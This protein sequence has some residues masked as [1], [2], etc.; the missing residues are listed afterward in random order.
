MPVI[1]LDIDG[2]RIEWKKIKIVVNIFNLHI[3]FE[4]SKWAKTKKGFHLYLYIDN[5]MK[6]EDICFFQLAMGSDSR[7]E[8]LNWFR[9]KYGKDFLKENWNVLFSKKYAVGLDG[10]VRLTS[11]EKELPISVLRKRLE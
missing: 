7:R 3:D 9:L 10:R 11:D 5:N 4:Q 1:K 8:M 6:E 2:K